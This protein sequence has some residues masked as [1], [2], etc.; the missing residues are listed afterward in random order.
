MCIRDRLVA[1]RDAKVKRFVYASSSSV[2][3]VRRDVLMQSR[4]LYG[5]KL[6]GHC[7]EPS[8]S[9]NID[10]PDDWA[11]AESLLRASCLLYT[12]RCV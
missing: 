8:Q 10:G 3:L 7:L 12:S 11:R 9:V 1:A 5:P 6:L 4:T 2:Y